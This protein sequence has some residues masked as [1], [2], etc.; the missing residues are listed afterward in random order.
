VNPR[1]RRLAGSHSRGNV[2]SSRTLNLGELRA[3][4]WLQALDGKVLELLEYDPRS[5][6]V[7]VMVDVAGPVD[8][9]RRVW[10]EELEDF[11]D[12]PAIVR[13]SSLQ[14]AN[15]LAGVVRSAPPA[16]PVAER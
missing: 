14:A 4:A 2:P 16:P 13:M 3:G 9:P 12:G 1:E 6:G 11:V 10:D 5:G 8:A 15:S 7:L